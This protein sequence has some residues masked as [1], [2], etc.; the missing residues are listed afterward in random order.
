MYSKKKKN[1][2][3]RAN[4][5][6]KRDFERDRKI[7][8]AFVLPVFMVALFG[9]FLGACD[10]AT[11]PAGDPGDKG[12]SCTVTD[13]GDGT[14]TISCEDGTE[15]TISDGTAGA[16]CTV[17]DNGDGTKTIS[18][19]DGTEVTVSDGTAGTA[20]TVTDNGD[21][22]VTI[23]CEDGTEVTVSDGTAGTSCTVV[24]NG[25]GTK[26]ITCED[27]TLVTVNDGTPGTST[28]TIIVTVMDAEGA[29]LEGA[30]VFT[31]PDT[32]EVDTDAT[33]V[34]TL[35]DVPVGIYNV[36]AAMDGYKTYTEA[37]VSVTSGATIN[38]EAILGEGSHWNLIMVVG[39]SGARGDTDVSTE[40]RVTLTAGDDFSI[41]SSGLRNVGVGNYVYL[42]G[43]D[44]DAHEEPITGWAWELTPAPGSAA[45]L[46][47]TDTGDATGATPRTFAA[48]PQTQ[49]AR[50]RPD[51][52]GR[53]TVTLTATLAAGTE[54]SSIDIY[55]GTYLGQQACASCHSN[56]SIVGEHKAVYDD[57]LLTG[58]AS[59]FLVQ[60]GSYS[61]SR[62]Y[63]LPCH[64]TG[65]D[66]SAANGGFDDMIALTGWDFTVDG[67]AGTW[68]ETFY[69]TL[70]D[71]LA[72]PETLPAQKLMNVQCEACHGPGSNHPEADAHITWWP[73]PCKQCHPQPNEWIMS[74]HSKFPSEHMATSTGCGVCH[75]GQGFVV[76][77]AHQEELVFPDNASADK[78]ANMFEGGNAQP[79]GCAT[80]HD[81]HQFTHP[82]D[83]GSAMKSD[84]L[85]FEGEMEAHQGFVVD[86]EKSA[87]CIYCH[88]NKRDAQYFTDYLAGNKSRGPHHN[89]Q[90]DILEG[91]GGY[92]YPGQDYS[93]TP[94]HSTL[95]ADKC[96]TCHMFHGSGTECTDSSECAI[97]ETC[98]HGHCAAVKMG[99]HTFNMEWTDPSD[100]TEYEL[101]D[102]CN[103]SGCHTGVTSFDRVPLGVTGDG[104]DCDAST[105]GI[106]S[107]IDNMLHMLET[108]LITGN[109]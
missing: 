47:F 93:D 108:C 78:P 68:L 60:Y 70:Q 101:V 84:Q 4:M 15:V 80:C 29:L 28:G 1:P 34:A 41:I 21:G 9:L 99:V 94:F 3:W 63:C 11:G 103:A 14:K 2:N 73:G 69:A 66:E 39:I 53:Y 33:G 54:E 87:A 64:A 91:K 17:T 30:E 90:A 44:M 25:D 109:S 52:P 85:R 79:I 55:A 100:G 104:W 10:G 102:A 36:R 19:D 58:H 67:S 48:T 40:K 89:G 18:C 8:A 72:A 5:H 6:T 88:S 42:T 45:A 98:S 96:V 20:C 27:G 31:D 62:D 22:T 83:G 95:A 26:T 77:V 82:Y 43:A 23:T 106:Q 57:Y 59:K 105:T 92:E 61:G 65:Y 74:A 81:P 51:V 56:S 16:A 13:N 35:E 86:A 49:F 50:L 7:L 107:E 76:G 37:G 97:W 71:F 75:T 46:E 24:D 32:S 38:I 12:G